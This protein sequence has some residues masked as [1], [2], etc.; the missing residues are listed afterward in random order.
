MERWIIES[1][2]FIFEKNLDQDPFKMY[3]ISFEF[4]SFWINLNFASKWILDQIEF[5]DQIIFLDQ[6]YIFGRIF[7]WKSQKKSL[8]VLFKYPCALIDRLREFWT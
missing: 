2:T 3:L 6:K 1:E 5:L 7:G 4:H 8:T